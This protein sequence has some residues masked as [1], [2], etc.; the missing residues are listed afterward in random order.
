MSKST[1]QIEAEKN[2]LRA[3][4]RYQEAQVEEAKDVLESEK[5]R[6]EKT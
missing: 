3:E 1:V 2:S 6:L 4:E 5:D